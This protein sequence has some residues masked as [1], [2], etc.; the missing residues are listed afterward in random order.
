M[1]AKEGD[2]ALDRRAAIQ[3]VWVGYWKGGDVGLRTSQ[4]PTLGAGML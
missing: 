2:K 3:C 4:S 1:A